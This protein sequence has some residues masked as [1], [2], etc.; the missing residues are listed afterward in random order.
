MHSWARAIAEGGPKA[1]ASTKDILQKCSRQ[2]LTMDEFAR[3]SAEPRLGDE[4]QVGLS[5]FF[6]KKPFA[7]GFPRHSKMSEPEI[8]Q[9]NVRAG[10]VSDGNF[11]S[12]PEA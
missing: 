9:Q 5:A 1:L 8:M 6:A 2:S 3:A 7:C 12:E 11:G 10:S 4:C